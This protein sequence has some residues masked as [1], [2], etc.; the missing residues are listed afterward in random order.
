MLTPHS[1]AATAR[2]WARSL[3]WGERW[4]VGD[5]A[6]CPL[7]RGLFAMVFDQRAEQGQVVDVAGRT[8]ADPVSQPLVGE[9]LVPGD[10]VGQPRGR[11]VDDDAGALRQPEPQAAGLPQVRRY[12]RLQDFRV[13]L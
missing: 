4:K 1:P 3:P 11:V 10:A 13:T 8:H 9:I 7:L 12:T 5:D 2:N 6:V